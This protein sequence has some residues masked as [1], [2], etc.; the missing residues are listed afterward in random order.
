MEQSPRMSLSYVMPAQ[1]QKHVTVNE[2]FRRL[3]ALTQMS[4]ASRS[5]SAEPASPAEGA[6][7]ILPSGASGDAWDSYSEHDIAVYQDG[8]WARIA[9]GEGFSAWVSDDDEFVVFDG[10]AWTELSGGGGSLETAAKFGVNTTAD[11]TNR[12]SVKSDAVLFNHDDVTPGSGDC[13]VKINKDGES[14]TATLLFQTG[15]S[16]RAEFGLA[17]DDDFQVKVSADGSS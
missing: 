15:A 2:T 11:T 12:L 6:A 17:G 9:P 16:G 3:D 10:A 14:D 4:V 1:A 13:Q 8:A 7:Y 5:E